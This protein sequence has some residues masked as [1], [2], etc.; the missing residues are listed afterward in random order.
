MAKFDDFLV[1]G[2]KVTENVARAFGWAIITDP[3]WA[4]GAKTDG[5]NAQPAIAAALAS[6]NKTVYI[7]TGTFTLTAALNLVSGKRITGAGPSSIL[8]ASS[9]VATALLL[10]TSGA[11]VSDTVLDNFK[12]DM[13]W[14]TGQSVT[15]AVQIT[16]GAR[17]TIESLHITGSG[18]AGILLQGLNANGG[19]SDCRIA[20]CFIDGTGLADLSTGFGIQLKDRSYGNVVTGNRLR[21]IKGG[22]GI[23]LNGTA[24]LGYASYNVITGNSVTMVPSTIGFESIGITAGCNHNTISHNVTEQSYDNGL[25][26]SGN[27]NTVIG[28]VVGA[29]WNHGIGVAGSGNTIVGNTIRNI[30]R[31]DSSQY[32]GVSID[33]GAW[34]TVTDNM[35]FDDNADASPNR[36][37]Y[38]VKFVASGGNNRVGPNQGYGQTVAEY[39]PLNS[40]RVPTDVVVSTAGQG[41][42]FEELSVSGPAAQPKV[43]RL[44]TAGSTRWGFVSD[45]TAESGANAGSNFLLNSYSDAGA[46]LG[47][48]LSITRATRDIKF[49]ADLE[50]NDATKGLI[51]K[52]PNG[53]RFRITVADDGALTTTSL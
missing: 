6:S 30:G 9:T 34:N 45:S 3:Q 31:Q 1:P 12:L 17:L 13:A 44:Q 21:G 42:S 27:Y 20:N 49:F 15:H 35:I 47:S 10:G 11:T 51:L 33:T 18:G 23:G 29:C 39:T 28:N 5:T 41:W 14:V 2:S 53:T 46:S 25:S 37:A 48:A 40:G 24:G 22:M 19:T 43:L 32:G 16:N 36:M 38:K 4:G 8:K 26:I 7:P 52:S 50:S